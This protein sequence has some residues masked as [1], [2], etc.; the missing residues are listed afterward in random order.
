M[1]RMKDRVTEHQ[2]TCCLRRVNS[3]DAR[4]NTSGVANDCTDYGNRERRHDS[5]EMPSSANSLTSGTEFHGASGYSPTLSTM[6]DVSR[7]KL[8]GLLASGFV[9]FLAAPSAVSAAPAIRAGDTCKKIGRRR[10]AGGK[11][12]ECVEQNGVRAW[13]RVQVS[14]APSEPSTSDVKVLDSS[15]LATGKSQ[16]VVVTSGGRNYAVV[17]T[18][19]PSGVVAFNRACTHQGTFVTVNSANQLYCI[20]H[21]SLF[22]LTTGAVIEGPASRALTQYKATERSGAI[23]VSI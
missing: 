19:T 17:V 23:Y 7:R 20:S 22:N 2:H 10:N 6:A 9:A 11:T 1:E 3:L 21:G 15:A 18:R 13:K 8:L 4:R 5:P 16:H 12:F 14:K